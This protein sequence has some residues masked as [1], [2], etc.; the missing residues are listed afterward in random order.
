[1]RLEPAVHRDGPVTLTVSTGGVHP[2]AAAWI[3][4]LAAGAIHPEHLV[5]L[6]L[7]AEVRATNPG[8][9]RP[10]WREA[11]RSGML[12]LIR[13]GRRAEAKERLK[14]CLSSSSD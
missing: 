6:D 12:D 5:A 2:G 10:D 13:E 14:A 9:H 8:G 1:M 4:D 3:R 7:A 11:V